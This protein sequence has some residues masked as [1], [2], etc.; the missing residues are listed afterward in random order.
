VF[1]FAELA[2]NFLNQRRHG[3]CLSKLTDLATPGR[4][5]KSQVLA[6]QMKHLHILR[7]LM[8]RQ[9]RK[10]KVKERGTQIAYRLWGGDGFRYH[11]RKGAIYQSDR[12]RARRKRGSQRKEKQ[13]NE[14]AMKKHKDPIDRASEDS[15]LASDPPSFTPT[16][17]SG[18]PHHSTQVTEVGGRTIVHAPNG[19]GEELRTHLAAHGIRSKVSP[20]AETTFERVEIEGDAETE[21]VQTIVDQWE[22]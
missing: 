7:D 6:D 15:F 22:D 8:L 17:G 3:S 21:D 13:I 1:R 20:A 9:H 19:R 10:L 14:D 18:D 11:L 5:L 16:I 12:Q 2:C 4:L